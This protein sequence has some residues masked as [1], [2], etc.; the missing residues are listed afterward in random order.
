MVRKGKNGFSIIINGEKNVL[1]K[2]MVN[3]QR[4]DGIGKLLSI[5]LMV[6]LMSSQIKLRSQTQ[7][8]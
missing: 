3:K 5:V 7:T 1:L 2:K 6:N 4:K 8:F